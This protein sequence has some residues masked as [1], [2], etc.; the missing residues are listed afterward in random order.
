VACARGG[1]SATRHRPASTASSSEALAIIAASLGRE[2][3]ESAYQH[4]LNHWKAIDAH[5][6]QVDANMIDLMVATER[7]M[8]WWEHEHVLEPVPQ[9][10]DNNPKAA[11]VRR[12]T[13]EHP[14]ATLKMRMGTTYFLMKTLRRTEMARH[15]LAYNLTRHEHP[16]HSTAH[17]SNEGIVTACRH[18][19]RS[20]LMTRLHPEL[21]SPAKRQYFFRTLRPRADLRSLAA[22]VHRQSHRRRL[23]TST[24]GMTAK[25]IYAVVMRGRIKPPQT[26]KVN[27][28]SIAKDQHGY[29]NV[30][31]RKF[32]F[33]GVA[34][35]KHSERVEQ[36]LPFLLFG[37]GGSHITMD[38]CSDEEAAYV[39]CRH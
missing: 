4:W 28:V 33:G 27:L 17:G 11:R 20:P 8:T 13:T 1:R 23:L 10:L 26:D 32:R 15:V 18:A 2:Q 14:C 19:V 3:L 36:I 16:R 35:P 38:L 9:R 30:S 39:G 6:P 12:E 21:A 34:G 37:S 31:A 29:D 25:R 5:C 22:R 7:R 24:G